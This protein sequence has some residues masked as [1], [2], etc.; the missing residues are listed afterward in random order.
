MSKNRNKTIAYMV[1]AF[2]AVYIHSFGVM[3]DKEEE[4]KKERKNKKEDR[5]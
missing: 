2:K 3:G 5:R 4:R 1:H